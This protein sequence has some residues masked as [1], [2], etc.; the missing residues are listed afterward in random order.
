[1]AFEYLRGI[2]VVFI[3]DEMMY[4]TDFIQ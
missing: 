4:N 2:I 1:V 3:F